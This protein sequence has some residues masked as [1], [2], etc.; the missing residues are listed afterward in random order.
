MAAENDEEPKDNRQLHLEEEDCLIKMERAETEMRSAQAALQHEVN[1]LRIYVARM[2]RRTIDR[3]NNEQEA[4]LVN[5][6]KAEDLERAA[7]GYTLSAPNPISKPLPNDRQL[8]E[9]DFQKRVV[10]R[11]IRADQRFET[12]FSNLTYKQLSDKLNE[13]DVTTIPALKVTTEAR[14]AEY[15]RARRMYMRKSTELRLMVE[16]NEGLT[17]SRRREFGKKQATLHPPF[18]ETVT[19][20]RP[21]KLMTS[22]LKEM[23]TNGPESLEPSP[24]LVTAPIQY[25][26]L[27]SFY[28][29]NYYQPEKWLTIVAKMPIR[30]PEMLVK[31]WMNKFGK[32]M[33]RATIELMLN[34]HLKP[35][36]SPPSPFSRQHPTSVDVQ[37]FSWPSV[38]FRRVAAATIDFG[39]CSLDWTLPALARAKGDVPHASSPRTMSPRDFGVPSRARRTS[40]CGRTTL[41]DN[42]T[43]LISIHFRRYHIVIYRTYLLPCDPN[44]SATPLF[45]AA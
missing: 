34:L 17:A 1:L 2:I 16:R 43:P 42:Y 21:E 36:H 26:L 29:Y 9:G 14:E 40:E 20:Y 23:K 8:H 11:F 15:V 6:W 41:D 28:Y 10:R 5:A 4:R 18:L 30:L 3:F 22:I 37:A 12:E 25:S 33:H 35:F 7:P 32:W 24:T 39:V 31:V 45:Y 44:G 38:L 19:A 13:L 27:S